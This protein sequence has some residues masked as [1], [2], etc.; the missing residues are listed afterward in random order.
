MPV[1]WEPTHV[2]WLSPVMSTLRVISVYLAPLCSDVPGPR[3]GNH[4]LWNLARSVFSACGQGLLPELDALHLQVFDP[5]HPQNV[6]LEAASG[7]GSL[8]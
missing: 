8:C 1:L 7:G 4:L 3:G 2:V 5:F 6:L